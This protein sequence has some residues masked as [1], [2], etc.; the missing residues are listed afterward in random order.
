MPFELTFERPWLLLLLGLLPLVW[1]LGFRSLAGLGG[2]RRILALLLRSIVL[3]LLVLALAEMSWQKR[4]DQL[5]VI[6]LL[7]QSESIPVAKRSAMLKFVFESVARH[8]R[9]KDKA[10]VVIFG[11]NARI[12]APPYEG[13]LPLIGELESDLALRTDATNLEAALKLAKASL[14]EDSA[15]R[16]VV[17]SDGNENLG[18]GLTV[19]RGLAADGIG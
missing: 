4:T 10:G 17:V 8:R 2:L 13:Q 19:A 14:P 18:D 1:W 15:G 7:D 16:I 9:E 11:A 6:Y 3:T 5:T 12:E